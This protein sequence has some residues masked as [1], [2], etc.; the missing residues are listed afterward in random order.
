MDSSRG[1]NWVFLPPKSSS[2]RR[3]TSHPQVSFPL[4]LTSIWPVR[5]P[6]VGWQGL[7]VFLPSQ[8]FMLA[9]LGDSQTRPTREVAPYRR[10]FLPR[11]WG[12]GDDGIDPD[13]FT[14]HYITVYQV[15][16]VVSKLGPGALKTEFVV[17]AA[18]RNVSVHPSHRVL[19]GMK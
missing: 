12:G 8:I 4:L 15:I 19:L 5:F 1:F 7:S 18:Y 6:K 13:K 2:L 17:E 11:G 3:T 9:V 16:R 10:P 14:L